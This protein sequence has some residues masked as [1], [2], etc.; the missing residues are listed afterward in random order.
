MNKIK[1]YWKAFVAALIGLG[2]MAV[3]ILNS[4]RR[5]A[6]RKAGKARDK[7]NVIHGQRLENERNAEIL[8]AEFTEL[9]EENDRL[10]QP[11]PPVVDLE[12]EWREELRK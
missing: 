1:K 6:I 3:A 8:D 10:I 12:A 2:L 11:L 9:R 7:V 4:R 5:G